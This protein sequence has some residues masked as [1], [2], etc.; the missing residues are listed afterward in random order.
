MSPIHAS[1]IYQIPLIRRIPV[2]FR[3]I[4]DPESGG[5]MRVCSTSAHLYRGNPMELKT[6]LIRAG[7]GRIPVRLLTGS[8]N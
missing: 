7:G 3:E 8:A 6:I 5:S 4:F 2:P 1:V